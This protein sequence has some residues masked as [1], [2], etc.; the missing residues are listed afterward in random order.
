M[1]TGEAE[2]GGRASRVSGSRRHAIPTCPPLKRAADVLG[3]AA[4]VLLLSPL[5][6]VAVLAVRLSS[7]GPVLFRQVR[8]G[9]DG[10][11]FEMLKLRTMYADSTD[12]LHQAYV[13]SMLLGH[14]T[15]PVNGLYK[16]DDDPRVTPVG[17][18]LRRS[19][20][21]ELPQLWNVLR[22]QMSL[23]GPRPVLPWEVE[24]F[25]DWAH[26]RF[27]VR[28]GLTGLWQVSGRNRLS[29]LEGLALDVHYVAR[30]TF[31]LDLFILARTLGA[32]LGRGAR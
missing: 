27:R 9:I 20:I 21:D 25:P 12:A 3:V 16:L 22:G 19:S 28:P 13:R 14:E 32:I 24:L 15:D 6:L 18:F 1:T 31:A 2:W 23:V 30:R 10:A 4:I 26:A 29:M 17:R 5:L 7:P 11:P 8:I